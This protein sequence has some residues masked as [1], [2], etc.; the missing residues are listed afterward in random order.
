MPGIIKNKIIQLVLFSSIYCL[1]VLW[2]GNLWLFIGLLVII[3]ITLIKKVK[4]RFWKNKNNPGSLKDDMLDTA[5]LAIIIAVFLRTFIAGVFVIPSPSMEN[6]LKDGDFILVSKLHYGPRMPMTPVNIPFLYN[7]IPGTY[8]RSYIKNV[9]FP[10]KRL[11]GFSKVKR[12]DVIVFNLPIGDKV[13]ARDTDIDYYAFKRQTDIANPLDSV[14]VLTHPIDKRQYYIKRCVGLPGDT[15]A[16]KNGQVV[17]NGNKS[18]NLENIKYNYLIKTDGNEIPY[19]ILKKLKISFDEIKLNKSTWLYE[20]SLTESDAKE[21]EALPTIKGI[22]KVERSE[23]SVFNY[24]IFPY[25]IH[26]LWAEDN[27]GPLLIPKKGLTVSIDIFNLPLYRRVIEI[28]EGKKLR[29]SNDKIYINEELK[30]NYT[31]EKDYYFVMGDNR[32]N[33]FDSRFWGFVPEN[34]IVGKAI[35]VWFSYNKRERGLKSVRWN[36]IFKI[37]K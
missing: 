11:K 30:N 23:G 28:Y 18:L 3:E 22:R 4:W 20:L 15:L 24:S 34:H 1:W 21:I 2:I 5:F 16:V 8:N 19:N 31:F 9:N 26:H 6:T 14:D 36:Q 17:I 29:L 32:H 35:F 25:S 27:F 13:I 37:I 12:E 7:I 33:S 10:Y